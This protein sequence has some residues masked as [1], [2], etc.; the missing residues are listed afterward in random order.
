MKPSSFTVIL[1]FVILMV[2]GAALAPLIDVGTEPA[3]RQ[4]KSMTIIYSWPNAAA[5]TVEQNLTSPVEGMVAALKGVESVSSKSYFGRSEIVVKLKEGTDVSAVRF[6][7]ASILRQSYDR[8][9]DGVSFPSISGGE[10]TSDQSG[11]GQTLLLTYNVNASM[12]QEQIKSFVEANFTRRLEAVEGVSRVEVTGT[13][14]T[15]IDITY[16]PILLSS[17][18]LTS[19]DMADGIGNYLGKDEI[20]GTVMHNVA[21]GKRERITLHLATAALGKSLGEMPLKNIGGKMVYLNDLAYVQT[22]QRDPEEYYRVNGLNTIYINVYI[23]SDGKAVK[24][25]DKVQDEMNDAIAS[26][27]QKQHNV[28]FRMSYDNAE[29]QRKEMSK[30]VGRTL[31]SLAILLV[32]VW[33]SY[34]DRKYLAIIATTLTANILI[35]IIAYWIFGLKLHVFS[36]AGITVSLGLVID[37]TIVMADHYGYYHNRKAF[38]AILA[39]MLTTIGAMIIIFFLPKELQNDLYD[40]AWIIIVNLVVSLLVAMFFVPAIIDRCGYTSKKRQLRHGR[41]IVRWNRFYRKYIQLTSRHRWVY[42]TLL[43]IAFG[44]PFGAMPEKIG[45]S[46][47]D[48]L[49]QNER[50]EQQLPWYCSAYNATIGSDFFQ[51]NMKAPL[52]KWLGGTLGM[53]INYLHE[54]GGRRD[55]DGEKELHIMASMPVGGTAVQLNQKMVVIEELLKKHKEIKEFTTRIN[56]RRGDIVV[57]FKKEAAKTSFPYQLENEAIGKM[58][59]IGGA[60]WSTYGISERGFSNSLNLQHRANRITVS[61]YNY[62][63]LYRI[64]EDVAD[65]MAQN[66]RVQDITIETPGFEN[67]ENEVY[68]Q[69]NRENM[70][71]MKVSPYRVHDALS[72]MLAPQHIGTYHSNDITADVTIRPT[73][74]A[75]FNLWHVRNE[76]IN[77]DSVQM[78][79]PDAMN[80]RQ[81]EAKNIIP[82]ENQEYVLNI[83]FNVLGSYVFTSEY[84]NNTIKNVNRILPVGYKCKTQQWRSSVTDGA[85]YWLLLLVVV[86]VFFVCAIQ[87]ESLRLAWIIISVIPLSMIGIFITFCATG[88]KFGSGGFASMVLLI[89]I[90]VNSG[91]Y[92]ISQYRM[93]IAQMAKSKNDKLIGYNEMTRCFIRAYNHKIIPVVLTIASTIMGL[94][95]FFLNGKDEQFWFSFATGVTGGLLFSVPAMIFLMPIFMGFGK[96]RFAYNP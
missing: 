63:Q 5:K 12:K 73:T 34:R 75:T 78:F 4:G 86:I 85:N 72:D 58:I 70:E 59:T 96:S 90:V 65:S 83:A 95:P 16:D 62:D 17:H 54:G 42:Y 61:G 6:E 76:Q 26:V 74:T 24:M 3:L 30:L 15:Y 94:I 60:D 69:Y 50:S 19:R 21:N 48:Y 11:N 8:L 10:V 18:G 67:Q 13:T 71:R 49:M 35:A 88:I 68:M 87:F 91:I 20:I 92:I 37:S 27:R 80:V 23:P 56:G 40:F 79:V 64:A 1:T 41:A 77:V 53:F 66:K 45:E 55:D 84:I 39:A 93:S 44:I 82:K 81:R 52:D 28:Y 29:N 7:I 47:N 9:P 2:V 43:I 89:G 38:L 51:H 32:F 36:L 31:M 25:S 14:D 57:K 33:M 22:R 46:D